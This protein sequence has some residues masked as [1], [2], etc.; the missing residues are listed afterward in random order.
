MGGATHPLSEALMWG[1]VHPRSAFQLY[2]KSMNTAR[3]NSDTAAEGEAYHKLGNITVLLGD[4]DKALEY[5]KRYVFF[6]PLD[7]K[8]PVDVYSA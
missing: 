8:L 5:Q 2:E 6:R 3:A 4:L 1:Y 7:T